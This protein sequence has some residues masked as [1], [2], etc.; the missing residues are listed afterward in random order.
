MDF[1][2]LEELIDLE[3]LEELKDLEDSEELNNPIV[4]LVFKGIVSGPTLVQTD[5]YS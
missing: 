2:D 1:E 5:P 3:D 4:D